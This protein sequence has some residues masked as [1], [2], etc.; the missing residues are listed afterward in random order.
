[1]KKLYGI[2]TGPGDKELV[3]IKA[4]KVMEDADIIFAPN[5]KGTN[6]ALDIVKEYIANKKVILLNLP[7]GQV[8]K[9]DYIKNAKIME[10]NI[11]EDK[12]GVFL[13]LGDP[14][15]YSTFIY[16]ME[17]I[18]EM[19]VQTE[20]VPGIPSF[21]AAAASSKTPLTLKGEKLLIIDEF[22]EN[23]LKNIDTFCLLKTWKDKEK[24][25]KEI[26]EEGFTYKYIKRATLEEEKIL[27]DEEEILKDK[28]YISLIIGRRNPR[29]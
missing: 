13:T 1:M 22:N 27:I 18:E 19:G 10:E 28:D 25:L 23:S 17:E 7:M 21:I 4:V 20:I 3:T 5:N 11:L 6:M 26:D 29:D 9:E 24:L 14:L 16:L 2:G 8:T 15:I 12:Y